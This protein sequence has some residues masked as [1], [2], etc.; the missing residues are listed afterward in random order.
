MKNIST[1]DQQIASKVRMFRINAG[2]T[3]MEVAG[4][5]GISPQQV[6]KYEQG[7]NKISAARLE[8][9]ANLFSISMSDFFID[10]ALGMSEESAEF[11][12]KL[13]RGTANMLRKYRAISS[14]P[15]R[16]IVR[17]VTYMLSDYDESRE[18]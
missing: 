11:I 5:L 14:P 12:H 6:Q 18:L 4:H 10:S 1:R 17:E 3:Q 9:M 2:M 16:K 7:K 15:L 8:A 13:D